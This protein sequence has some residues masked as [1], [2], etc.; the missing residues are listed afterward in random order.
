MIPLLSAEDVHRIRGLNGWIIWTYR[1][2]SSEA[3]KPG[4]LFAFYVQERKGVALY[5]HLTS[6]HWQKPEE[7][8]GK[9]GIM[10]R[11]LALFKSGRNLHYFRTEDWCF[12]SPHYSSCYIPAECP[13]R[14]R[15]GQE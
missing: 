12:D 15:R 10:S 8:G 3:H 2:E 4:D 7:C 1:G 5:A 14:E 6:D 13:E 11:T 9:Q